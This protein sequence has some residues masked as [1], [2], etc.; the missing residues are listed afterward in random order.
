MCVKIIEYKIERKRQRER[1]SRW[2]E[3]RKEGMRIYVCLSI[4][5][6]EITSKLTA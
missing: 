2:D 5:I 6:V 1:E 3:N 4:F